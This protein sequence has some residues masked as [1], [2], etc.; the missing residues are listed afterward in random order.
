MNLT[1]ITQ[2]ERSQTQEP[3]CGMIHLYKMSRMD[4]STE[5]ESGSIVASGQGWEVL[6]IGRGSPFWGDGN[7]L[8]LDRGDGLYNCECNKC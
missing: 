1:I 2:R 8:E 6:F 3:T 5:T 4:K 7:I